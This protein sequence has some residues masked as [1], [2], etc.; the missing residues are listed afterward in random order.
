M[1]KGKSAKP[2][3]S[4]EDQVR[5]DENKDYQEGEQMPL[6]DVEPE[7]AKEI[8][9][10]AKLYKSAQKRRMSALQEEIA[11]KKL[12]LELVRNS[13]VGKL[14]D[15]K[16]KFKTGTFT[17]IVTPR[18]EL[19]KVKDESDEDEIADEEELNDNNL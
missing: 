3:K 5:Q 11:E 8:I 18:D 2:R 19:V 15:G 16:I 1:V 17:V 14:D 4:M 12:L 6:I 9:K 7:N 10:H 13:G